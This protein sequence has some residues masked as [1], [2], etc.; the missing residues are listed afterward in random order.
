MYVCMYVYLNVNLCLCASKFTRVVQT[1]TRITT[2]ANQRLL[3]FGLF[4]EI[5]CLQKTLEKP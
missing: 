4:L 1:R 3:I 2:T 5:T